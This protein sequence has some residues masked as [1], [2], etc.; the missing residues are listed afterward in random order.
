MAQKAQVS[1]VNRAGGDILLQ[2][3]M[4]L[5]CLKE[6]KKEEDICFSCGT[7]PLLFGGNSG[8]ILNRIPLSHVLKS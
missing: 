1:L 8:L 4:L 3:T 2:E 5:L 6:K 7:G